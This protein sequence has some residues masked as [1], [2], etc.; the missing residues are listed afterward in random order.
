[1]RQPWA[2][3]PVVAARLLQVVLLAPRAMALPVLAPL[4]AALPVGTPVPGA[5]TARL[6]EVGQPRSLR[7]PQP[8]SETPGCT[9][10]T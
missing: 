9:S 8:G 10:G 1:V 2:L 4:R 3:T 5:R 6:A 7:L